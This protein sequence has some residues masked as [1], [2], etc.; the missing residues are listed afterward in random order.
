MIH[1][2]L[3]RLCFIERQSRC[4]ATEIGGSYTRKIYAT[5][6]TYVNTLF[7]FAMT[8]TSLLLRRPDI[9]QVFPFP[10]QTVPA[11]HC[12]GLLTQNGPVHT[13]KAEDKPLPNSN[14]MGVTDH[15]CRIHRSQISLHVQTICAVC[16]VYH[17]LKAHADS[18]V[19]FRSKINLRPE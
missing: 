8:S 14:E 11:G 12:S 10:Q 9:A 17:S 15:L 19:A 4:L 3:T 5:M 7:P 6:F 2:I 1:I 16:V 18:F 13:T